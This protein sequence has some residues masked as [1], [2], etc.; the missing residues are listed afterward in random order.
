MFV[1][2]KRYSVYMTTNFKKTVLYVGMTN[3]LEQRII[4]HYI[5]RDKPGSFTGK[6][7]AYNLLYFECYD[8]VYDAISREK[9][10]KGWSRKKKENLIKSKNPNWEFLNK[11]LFGKWPPDQRNQVSRKDN[12][13]D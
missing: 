9:Q 4:E 6:Y 13:L 2:D 11:K 1:T 10:I 5:Q 12:Y 7:H 3:N 8:Y